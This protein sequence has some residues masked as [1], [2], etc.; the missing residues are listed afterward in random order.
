M[1][2]DQAWIAELIELQK[3]AAE[4]GQGKNS[5]GDVQGLVMEVLKKW[6]IN[7][8]PWDGDLESMMWSKGA[9]ARKSGPDFNIDISETKNNVLI[10][11]S[12][13]GIT[14]EKEISIKLSGETLMIFGKIGHP[15]NDAGYFSRKIRLP[16]EVTTMDAEAIYRDDLLTITLPKTTKEDEAT[17]PLRFS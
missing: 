16:A 11:A 5:A 1:I 15:E 17:I 12:I 4:L 6:G 2:F 7:N 8:L 13:P 10:R 9:P 14:D 3:K